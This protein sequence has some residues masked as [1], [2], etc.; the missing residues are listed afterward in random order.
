MRASAHFHHFSSA[1]GWNP[2]LVFG[3]MHPA[4]SRRPASFAV[5]PMQTKAFSK[6]CNV[7]K[8][9]TPSNVCVYT[10]VLTPVLLRVS[11]HTVQ[12]PQRPP[13]TKRAAPEGRLFLFWALRDLASSR[14]R[15]VRSRQ[16]AS[17]PLG[18]SMR[19]GLAYARHGAS[20]QI[21]HR[22]KIKT[23]QANRPIEFLWALRDLNPR[24]PGCKPGALTS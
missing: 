13:N 6:Q 22:Q 10:H 16:P 20:V 21:P 19:L 3:R 2:Y 8:G 1:N 11:Q 4:C 17:A 23:R 14:A 24:H 5:A 18:A 15:R 12:I 7:G 9:D